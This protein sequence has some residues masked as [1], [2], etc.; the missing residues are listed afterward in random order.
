MTNKPKNLIFIGSKELGL[1]AM[2]TIFNLAPSSLT[3]VISFDDS[4]DSRSSFPEFSRFCKDNNV[5]L[6]ILK[7]PSDLSREIKKNKPE[8]CIVIGWYWIIKSELLKNI[9]LGFF[10]V[11]ASLL[12]KYRGC[13]PTVWA[14][15]NGENQHG[16]TLFRFDNG[17]DTGDILAQNTFDIKENDYIS[18]VL[19]KIESETIK[20]MHDSIPRILA[21]DYKVRRQ[22]HRQAS[23]CAQRRPEDGHIDW[24]KSCF[25]IY[26]FIR[27]QSRPYPG[28]FS[29]LENGKTLRIWRSEIF[30][31]DYY[32]VPGVISQVSHD[33]AVITCGKGALKLLEVQIDNSKSNC[34]MGNLKYGMRL[35]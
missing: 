6:T 22:D 7:K 25:E 10:G 3:R 32:G 12:P 24:N 9:S 33:H 8:I 2:K 4:N 26:N 1:K 11:H 29:N 17:I 5:N 30:P 14:I 23:Y 18:D 15:I 13:S 20:I 27:A 16:V 34:V 19:Q 28:A 21:G 31:A 35:T